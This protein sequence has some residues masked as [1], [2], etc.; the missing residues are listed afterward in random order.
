MTTRNG[1]DSDASQSGGKLDDFILEH[2]PKDAY[3]IAVGMPKWAQRA[4]V[5]NVHAGFEDP[6]KLT[7]ER[8]RLL[9]RDALRAQAF[10]N[11]EEEAK[12]RKKA[13]FAR[14]KEVE[15]HGKTEAALAKEA[16]EREKAQAE[17]AS[18]ITKD[19]SRTRVATANRTDQAREARDAAWALWE[20]CR[21][22]HPKATRS[23]E[24]VLSWIQGELLKQ[25]KIGRSNGTIRNYLFYNKDTD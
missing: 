15:R 18:R 20:E 1:P 12:K 8:L 16:E 13:E 23:D 21:V 4:L 5:H 2:L 14:A 22:N 10:V 17:L 11:Q 25:H 7:P 6:E 24:R 9:D 19:K 3:R